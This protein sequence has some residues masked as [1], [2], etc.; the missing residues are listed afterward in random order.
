MIDIE[1]EIGMKRYLQFCI[2]WFVMTSVF[3]SAHAE[4]KQPSYFP[5]LAFH[6]I[7]KH[8]RFVQEWYQKNLLA[9]EE[10]A[11]YP[12]KD[13]QEIYRFTWLRT[14][15]APM[16]FRVVVFADGAG[17]LLV[18]RLNG[19]GGYEPGVVDLRKTIPLAT[20]AIEILR[21]TLRTTKFWDK[22]TTV[23]D[24]GMDGA[25]WIIEANQG[26][27]Y[28]IVDRWSGEDAGV[29]TFGQFLINMS[30]VEVGEIY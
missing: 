21:E 10:P 29:A 22:P 27:R 20:G 24:E 8:D 7:E 1:Q 9:M 28:K 2:F 6:K 5:P 26:G 14:F 17:E 16:A 3:P 19:K 13:A 30:G 18:T 11:L 15:H 25:Q 12:P 23:E 4:E